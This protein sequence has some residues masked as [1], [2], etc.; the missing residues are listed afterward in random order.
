MK[1]LLVG[2]GASFLPLWR[3]A[4]AE[5][6]MNFWEYLSYVRQDEYWVLHIPYDQAV[7]EAETAWRLR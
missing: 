4:G 7:E 3:A 5:K 6:G 2:L 1:W